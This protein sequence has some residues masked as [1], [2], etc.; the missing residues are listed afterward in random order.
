MTFE[1]STAQELAPK[2]NC[3][4]EGPEQEVS[5]VSAQGA[6]CLAPVTAE[7][8]R[9]GAAQEEQAAHGS[10]PEALQV[11]PAAQDSRDLPEAVAVAEAVA[12]DVAVAEAV[13]DP[14]VETVADS[15]RLGDGETVPLPVGDDWAVAVGE[16]VEVTDTVDA[17]VA[18]VCT[19]SPVTIRLSIRSVPPR[20][21]PHSMPQYRMQQAPYAEFAAVAGKVIGDDD[22]S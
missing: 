5:A 20:A 16:A 12:V 4:T 6:S 1:T 13:R 7:A 21:P 17:G 18:V 22:I 11:V 9:T 14:V 10:V 3:A 19:R 8:V 2:L 15:E